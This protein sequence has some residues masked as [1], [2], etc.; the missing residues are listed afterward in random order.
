VSLSG[1]SLFLTVLGLGLLFLA[2]EFAI[3]S[4]IALLSELVPEKRST[5]MA[6]FFAI[7]T[8]GRAGGAIFGPRLWGATENFFVHGIVSLL[9]IGGAFLVGWSVLREQKVGR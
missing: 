5:L 8:A 9:T 2:F 6:V 3:V 1:S 4:N 7:M